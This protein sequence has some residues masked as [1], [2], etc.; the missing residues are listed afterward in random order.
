MADLTNTQHKCKLCGNIFSDAEMSDEHYP[1]RSTG[2]NDIVLVNL[3]KMIDSFLSNTFRSEIITRMAAGETYEDIA[4]DIFD[5]S[6]STPIYPTGRTSRTLCRTCNTFLGKYD[7]AYLKFFNANGNPKSVKGFQK[8]TKYQIIKAIYAKFLSLPEAAD[9][10]FDFI[11]F[12]RD[13]NS[14]TYDGPWSI[15][16]V[17]RDFSSDFF[18]MKDIG[19]GKMPFNEGVVYELSDDK[20]IFNLMNFP[21]HDCFNMTNIFDILDK[22]YT[23]VEGVDESGGY[24]GQILMTRLFSSMLEEAK[25]IFTGPEYNRPI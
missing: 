19:T 6:L 23:L 12:I 11:D 3:T 9:E 24:H 17:K 8:Q 7:E 1:A 4:G 13:E 22:N 20:F 15:Y 25:Q 14:F 18:G 16:F 10:T 21:K 2:N 5:T